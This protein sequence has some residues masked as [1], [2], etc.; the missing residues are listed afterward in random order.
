MQRLPAQQSLTKMHLLFIS[1]INLSI[2]YCVTHVKKKCA[3]HSHQLRSFKKGNSLFNEDQ[4]NG[5]QPGELSQNIQILSSARRWAT[6]V[7]IYR[8]KAIVD[9]FVNVTIY[10]IKTL[11]TVQILKRWT[12][13]APNNRARRV[14][15]E[16]HGNQYSIRTITA[17]P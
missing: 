6:E 12:P 9:L 10:C 14:W 15:Q 4:N 1:H 5:I 3:K 2:A 11:Y 13:S 17:T 8:Y 16:D 7:V